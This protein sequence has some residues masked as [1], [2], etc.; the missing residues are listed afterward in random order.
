MNNEKVIL[1]PNITNNKILSTHLLY[2]IE[3]IEE[4]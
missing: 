3:E 2:E 1:K 4:I